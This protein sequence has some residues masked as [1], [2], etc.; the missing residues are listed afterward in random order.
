MIPIT[1]H[2]DNKFDVKYVWKTSAGSVLDISAATPTATAI[3]VADGRVVSMVTVVHDGLGGV[4]R[5][6]VDGADLYAGE[7]ELQM[8][9]DLSDDHQTK[10]HKITIKQSHVTS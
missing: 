2:T 10:T 8:S 4:Q 5:V 7:W 1:M 9:L 3:N 6:R